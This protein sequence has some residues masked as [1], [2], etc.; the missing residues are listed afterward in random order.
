MS[1]ENSIGEVIQFYK[2]QKNTF[3][4]VTH[5]SCSRHG[6]KHQDYSQMNEHIAKITLPVEGIVCAGCAE[7]VE[8]ILG[9]TDGVVSV[10]VNYGE[11]KIYL[12]FDPE[13]ITEVQ[14]VER[15]RKLGLNVKKK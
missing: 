9:D 12:Q 10:S 4:R 14:L 15:I 11:G 2:S 6:K 7:D 5:S 1:C 3:P 8:T 13:E